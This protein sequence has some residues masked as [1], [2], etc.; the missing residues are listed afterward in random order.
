[1]NIIFPTQLFIKKTCYDYLDISANLL[2]KST[3]VRK[4]ESMIDTWN[5]EKCNLNCPNL[6]EIIK[7]Y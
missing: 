5:R 7:K 4:L 3:Y 1:M 6:P 2:C